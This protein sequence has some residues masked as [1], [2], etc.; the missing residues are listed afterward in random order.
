MMLKFIYSKPKQ[1]MKSYNWKLIEILA[2]IK[3]FIHLWANTIYGFYRDEFLYLAQGEHLDVGYMEV[4]PMIAVVAK[5]TLSLGVIF[6]FSK[7]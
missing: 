7:I 3:L 2:S 1:F 4:P 6:I 5:I